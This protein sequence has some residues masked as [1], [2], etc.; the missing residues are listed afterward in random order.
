L[1]LG[2]S[3]PLLPHK[4]EKWKDFGD[5]GRCEDGSVDAVILGLIIHEYNN[6]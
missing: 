1:I 5:F 2:T 3:K 6:T 4:T